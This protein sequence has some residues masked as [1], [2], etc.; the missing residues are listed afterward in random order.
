MYLSIRDKK[1]G[2]INIFLENDI[3][4]GKFLTVRRLIK[5]YSDVSFSFLNKTH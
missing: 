2:F 1:I 5:L 3:N 4:L